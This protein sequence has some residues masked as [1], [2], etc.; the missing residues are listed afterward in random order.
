[1]R[2]DQ[3]Y[4]VESLDH[5]GQLRGDLASDLPGRIGGVCTLT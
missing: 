5:H 1:M 4:I 2:R 3:L